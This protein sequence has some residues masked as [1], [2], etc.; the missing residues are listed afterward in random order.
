MNPKPGGRANDTPKIA[1]GVQELPRPPE[2]PLT[3]VTMSPQGPPDG[4]TGV[5][6]DGAKGLPEDIAPNTLPR[7]PEGDEAATKNTQITVPPEVMAAI[8]GF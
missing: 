3:V 2:A 6:D 5:S 7:P 8:E 1:I 4:T